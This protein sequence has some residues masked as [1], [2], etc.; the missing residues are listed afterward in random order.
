MNSIQVLEVA[1]QLYFMECKSK[2]VSKIMED[3]MGMVELCMHPKQ[4]LHCKDCM[5]SVASVLDQ[6]FSCCT[7]YLLCGRYH[8]RQQHTDS[9]YGPTQRRPT[10]KCV[11]WFHISTRSPYLPIF[12]HFTSHFNILRQ[13]LTFYVR[14]WH[15]TSGFDIL[16]QDFTFYIRIWHFTSGF[17]VLRLKFDIWQWNSSSDLK[18][19]HL[20]VKFDIWP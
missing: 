9:S 4:C 12:L 14:I 6:S 13:D 7:K 17:Y 1:V 19:Q 11:N 18:I 20:T 10:A 3:Q 5:I 15:F 16:R 8:R 2:C